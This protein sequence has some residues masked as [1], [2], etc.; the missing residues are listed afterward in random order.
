MVELA[1]D[2]A[3]RPDRFQVLAL[4]GGGAKALFT[5]QVLARLEADLDVAVGDSFDLIAGTSAGGIIALAIGAGLR[6][7][8]IVERYDQLVTTVFPRGRRRWWRALARVAHPTY[9]PE[10]LRSVLSEIFGDRR[11][12]DSTKRLVITSWD[13]HNG[14]VHLFKTSHHPRLRRDWRIPMVDVAMATSA[15][16]AYLPAARVDEHRLVDGGVWANN[17]S[18]VAI[19][20]AV[21]MLRI[22]LGAIRVLNVGTTTELR[23][24]P[25][26][27][28]TGGVGMWARQVV[29]LILTATSHG[30]QGLAEHLVGRENFHRFDVQVPGGIYALDDAEPSALASH[31]AAVSRQV[32]PVFAEVFADHRAPTFR[33]VVGGALHTSATPSQTGDQ[34]AT[35]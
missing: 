27:L 18:T 24:H 6:P 19:A 5:A 34:G 31:A 28:D 32:S 8:E 14:N 20:E 4:D 2:A 25:K 35:C 1:A 23:D 26:R 11:L 13:V 33:P 16:P 21:S 3:E 10:P 9:D 29:P 12:G 15:A 7:A 30:H 17:P 22:P